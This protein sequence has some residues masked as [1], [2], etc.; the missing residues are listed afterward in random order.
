V[1]FLV[2]PSSFA[3]GYKS[4]MRDV[5]GEIAPRLHP[6]DL[7]VVGQPE[8]TTLAWYYLPG[9]LRYANT[10]GPVS[11]PTYMNWSGALGRLQAANPQAMLGPLVA[12]LRPGQQLLYVRP[13]T[14]GVENWRASWTELVRRRS[15][16]W[17]AILTSDVA[18]GRLKP[19]ATAPQNYRGSCCVADSAMLY[20][21]ISSP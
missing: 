21:K 20:Q 9:G 17:G 19:V 14:E 12:S 13:L 4:D 6:G 8:Q 3:P 10:T 15:A 16:Q 11:D 5:A 7:V 2:H 18:A 1:A